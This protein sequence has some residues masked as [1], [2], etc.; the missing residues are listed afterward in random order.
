MTNLVKRSPF[1]GNIARSDTFS[2]PDDWFNNFWMPRPFSADMEAI[3]PI[4]I[5]I[6]EN[7]K[8]YTIRAEIPGVKK[9]DIKVQVDGNLV[10]I[11]TETKQKKEK[12]EDGRVVCSECSQGSSYRS[13]TLESNINEAKSQAKFEDGML[14][15]TLPKKNGAGA[16]QLKIK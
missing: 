13:F 6:T 16:K 11:S 8:A 5:D 7:D 2:N 12:K 1:L 15:L 9:G 10:S 14:E 3:S 4:K